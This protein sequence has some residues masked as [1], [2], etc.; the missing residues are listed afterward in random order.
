LITHFAAEPQ[1][2]KLQLRRI[3]RMHG[4][5][6]DS[7]K[8]KQPQVFTASFAPPLPTGLSLLPHSTGYGTF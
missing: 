6:D 7:G 3:L 8:D 2:E 4:I 1:W 5:V